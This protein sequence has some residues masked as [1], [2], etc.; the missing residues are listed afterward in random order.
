MVTSAEHRE[1]EGYL[2]LAWETGERRACQVIGIAPRTADG[3]LHLFVAV[4]RTSKCV[5][6]RL[7]ERTITETVRAVLQALIAAIPPPNPY[8]SDGQ[9]KPVRQTNGQV[10]RMNRTLKWAMSSEITPKPTATSK[11]VSLPSWTTMTSPDDSGPRGALHPPKP[12]A[13][14]EPTRRTASGSTPSR[15]TSRLN[16]QDAV[17]IVDPTESATISHVAI[18]PTRASAAQIP[19][20]A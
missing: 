5:C 8:G 15:L 11:I 18:S 16:T 4:D 7:M 6:T 2:K 12:S 17:L 13:R 19:M 20:R 3:K 14:P 1:A 10:E 9:R